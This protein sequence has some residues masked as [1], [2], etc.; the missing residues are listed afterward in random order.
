MIPASQVVV[1]SAK[2]YKSLLARGIVLT[3][4]D[5]DKKETQLR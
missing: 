3:I 1:T 5:K 4:G 2:R